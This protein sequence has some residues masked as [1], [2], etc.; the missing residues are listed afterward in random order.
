MADRSNM[1]EQARRVVE[2]LRQEG[3][4][5]YFAGG[6]VRDRIMGLPPKDIDIAT[7]A[8]PERVQQLFPRTVPI[9]KAFGVILVVEGANQFEV[10]TFR[11]DGRYVDGRHPEDVTYSDLDH[12]A[13]RRDFTINAMYYDPVNDAFIDRVGGRD[14]VRARRIRT[15]GDP[16]RRFEEDKLRMMRAIRFGCELEFELDPDILTATRNLAPSLAQVSFERI[17]DELARIL[18]TRRA[19]EGIRRLHD[20]RL[21][22][23]FLPE[24]RR[25]VGVEQPPQFHPEGDVFTHTLLCLEELGRY[26]FDDTHPG[27]DDDPPPKPSFEVA[28]ATLLHDVAKPATFRVA[29]RI[30]FDGHDSRGA[31]MSRSICN[32]L[33]L[34]RAQR[35]RVVWLVGNHLRFISVPQMRR[36]TL[37]RMLGHEYYADLEQV[38]IADTMGSH[39]NLDLLKIL[40][41]RALEFAAEELKPKAL[42]T[43]RDLIDQGFRPGPIFSKILNA[44]YTAQLEGELNDREAALDWVKRGYRPDGKNPN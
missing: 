38:F 44:A 25:M 33:R 17:R 37:R 8:T 36:S 13:A 42:L 7:S 10:A 29:E 26:W 3:H 23:V 41:K 15:V 39:K 4:E 32:R 40:R 2:R 34:S 9:G 1:I 11:A 19:A 30:R 18:V 27:R 12:D 21:L 28:L 6:C 5:A 31:E 24:I 35:E 14:D 16:A 20:V 43:G 22:D